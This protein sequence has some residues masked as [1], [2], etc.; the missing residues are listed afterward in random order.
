MKHL[1]AFH[2]NTKLPKNNISSVDLTNASLTIRKSFTVN[3]SANQLSTPV[4]AGTNETFLPFD[5]ERYSLI[6]SDGTTEVLTSD[7]FAFI[8]G[9]TQLQIYN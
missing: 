1:I 2:V 8:S 5:E 3:I 6:R 9:S 7:K 4:S